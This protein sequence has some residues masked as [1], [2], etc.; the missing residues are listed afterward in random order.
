MSKIF[1]FIVGV[2]LAMPALAKEIITVYSPY[3]AGHAGTAA[4]HRVFEVANNNQSRYQFMLELK[5]GAQGIIA[6]RTMTEAPSTRLAII[7]ASFV[8]NVDN[9]KIHEQDYVPVHVDGNACWAVAT[10]YGNEKLGLASIKGLNEIMVGTVG[11]GNATHLTALQ[12]GEKYNI[13]VKYVGFKSN[14]DALINM[15]GNNGVNFILERVSVINQFRDKNPKMQMLAMSCPKRHPEAPNVKT[16]I[17]QGVT[18]PYVFN[19]VV[20]GRA[21]PE[22]KRQELG[23]ILGQAT[24]Q[25]GAEE[26]RRLSDMR[27]SI[28]DNVSVD[29]FHRQNVS[30]V[31]ALRQKHKSAII[32]TRD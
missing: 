28:F 1:T 29:D 2:I 17:E 32:E 4:S 9:G 11:V 25:V 8:E 30:T 20:A 18:A 12:I 6:L 13:P 16:L 10:T 31:R 21:M 26:I 23:K 19:T 24:L 7:N 15:V 3:S 5:P 14:Y 22:D 27:P